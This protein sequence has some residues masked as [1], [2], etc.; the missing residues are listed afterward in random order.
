MF[1]YWLETIGMIDFSRHAD[2]TLLSLLD[3][4]VEPTGRH[5]YGREPDGQPSVPWGWQDLLRDEE[6]VAAELADSDAARSRDPGSDD[7][8][9]RAPG[10]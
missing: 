1:A 3:H 9:S 6:S 7:A 2:V 8:E 10:L 5:R 4:R